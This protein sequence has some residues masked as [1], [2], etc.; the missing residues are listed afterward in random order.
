MA[1]FPL[2]CSICPITPLTSSVLFPS[3]GPLSSCIA[4]PMITYTRRRTEHYKLQFP[5]ERKHASVVALHLAHYEWSM[6]CPAK[7]MFLYNGI[8]FHLACVLHFII[9]YISLRLISQT[10]LEQ[11]PASKTP[12]AHPSTLIFHWGNKHLDYMSLER[13]HT[14]HPAGVWK[15]RQSM[16]FTSC[17][18]MIGDMGSQIIVPDQASRKPNAVR[19]PC[20]S[21]GTLLII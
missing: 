3:Q 14:K 4:S 12:L 19:L 20:L 21:Y 1:S 18:H 8:K 5:R 15:Y 6:H 13:N 9:F 17:E 2:R 7:F 16:L 10:C 11:V